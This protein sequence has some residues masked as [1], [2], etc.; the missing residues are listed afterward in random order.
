MPILSYFDPEEKHTLSVDTHHMNTDYSA[1]E[2]KEV[3]GKTKTVI[4][5]GKVAVDD[6]DVKID[7]G[8]GQFVFRN[9]VDGKL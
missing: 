2:G 6:G 9:K 4:L 5:R 1:Y 8:Y 7:K 3:T